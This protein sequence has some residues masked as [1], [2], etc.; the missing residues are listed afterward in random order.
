[1]KLEDM[2]AELASS[3]IYT[4][5]RIINGILDKKQD[6]FPHLAR[7]ATFQEYW[8]YE[9]YAGSAP[10]CALHLLAKTQHHN[11]H[12]VIGTVLFGYYEDMG[13]WLTELSSYVLAHLGVDI[14][15]ILTALVKYSDANMY[16]RDAAARALYVIAAQYPHTKPGIL[17]AIKNIIQDEPDIETRSLIAWN[18]LDLKEPSMYGWLKN[19]VKTGLV[20]TAFFNTYDIEREYAD[21]NPS[22]DLDPIDPLEV[23]SY[24]SHD[25][26]SWLEGGWGSMPK[27]SLFTQLG[28]KMRKMFRMS[29]GKSGSNP[30]IRTNFC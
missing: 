27:E 15:P 4:D 29:P 25:E 12:L 5:E 23:F 26:Y 24:N 3:G 30:K 8:R 9:E 22:R 21:K 28:Q 1:M 10:L 13:D 16:V 17:S 2:I 7:I 18:M 19:S 11:A 6:A 14:I 20:S